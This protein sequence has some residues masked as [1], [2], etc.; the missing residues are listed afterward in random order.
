MANNSKSIEAVCSFCSQASDEM[1]HGQNGDICSSCVKLA[2]ESLELYEMSR[3]VVPTVPKPSQIK[4][5]LD[6]HVIGQDQAKRT[7]AVAVYNHYQR[8]QSNL[9]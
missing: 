6:E 1:A 8:I 9:E 2:L 5:L 7:L 4:A 3:N